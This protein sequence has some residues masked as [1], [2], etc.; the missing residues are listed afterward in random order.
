MIITSE[1]ELYKAQPLMYWD[2]GTK[3]M[4]EEVEWDM[5][6]K[7]WIATVKDASFAGPEYQMTFR[8]DTNP[9]APLFWVDF[10]SV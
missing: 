10:Y 2:F 1:K 6:T 4:F 7:Y 9:Y 5:R 8:L 3:R